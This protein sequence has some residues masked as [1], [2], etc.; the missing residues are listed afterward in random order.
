MANSKTPCFICNEDK[1]TYSCK[2][3]SKEFCLIHLTEH[4]QTLTNELHY[5][6][7]QYNEFKQ[8]IHEQKQNP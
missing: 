6:T 2:G 8:K 3:C 1:I 7:N 5:I 4:R